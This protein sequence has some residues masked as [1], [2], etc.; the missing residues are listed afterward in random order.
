[1]VSYSSWYNAAIIDASLKWSLTVTDYL[2][3]FHKLAQKLLKLCRLREMFFVAQHIHQLVANFEAASHVL[4][5]LVHP[6]RDVLQLLL[7]CRPRILGRCAHAIAVRCCGLARAASR[8][9]R[10]C[11]RGRG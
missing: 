8:L 1:M 9:R 2:N 6:A 5:D 4:H 3:E 11:G 10:G 7:R